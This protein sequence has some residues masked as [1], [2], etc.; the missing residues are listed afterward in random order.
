MICTRTWNVAVGLGGSPDIFS[1]DGVEAGHQTDIRY[2]EKRLLVRHHERADS[3]QSSSFV[4]FFHLHL[5]LQ[6]PLYRI[7]R[8]RHF[9]HHIRELGLGC[10][11][12]LGLINGRSH[13]NLEGWRPSSECSPIGI[14]VHPHTF[15][16]NQTVPHLDAS[17]FSFTTSIDIGHHHLLINL[18]T[19][20]KS[21]HNHR[22]QSFLQ[23][24][25]CLELR[26]QILLLCNTTAATAALC[27]PAGYCS[28]RCTCWSARWLL[29]CRC[30]SRR[31]HWGTDRSHNWC[32]GGGY[33]CGGWCRR[34]H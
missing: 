13:A 26:I 10:R 5:F 6:C 8:S 14:P 1:F 34:W 18:H 16:A 2:V 29:L 15:H 17:L 21:A 27:T 19:K 22:H 28:C 9:L 4:F 32:R 20:W 25:E 33:W 23:V 30:W 31:H 3:V 12:R 7:H 11:C 24:L